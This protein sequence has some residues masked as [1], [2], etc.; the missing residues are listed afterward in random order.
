MFDFLKGGKATVKVTVDRPVQPYWLGET[1]QA[2]VTVNG[3]KDLKV[4]QARC[5]LVFHEEYEYRYRDT[6]RDSDGHEHTEEKRSWVTQEQVVQKELMSG[7]TT[8][9]GG[10]SQTFQYR[11]AIPPNAAPTASTGKIVKVKWLLKGILD[12][13]LLPDIA[14]N[15]EL[16]VFTTPPNQNVNPGLFGSSN[17]PGEAEL[18]FSLPRLEWVLGETLAGEFHIKPNKEFDAT[19]I[20]VELVRR[21]WV[22]RDLGNE[23]IERFAVK[24][25]QGTHFTPGQNM[26]LPFNF[27]LPQSAPATF[28]TPNSCV[29]WKV[30]GVLAR[31]LRGDTRAD[32]EIFVYNKHTA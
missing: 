30:S 12:R 15:V 5:E 25:A 7:E 21:E 31:R 16:L 9:K 2:T 19:E 1:V 29:E 23:S 8:I 24:L 13:K 11:F 32:Q 10:T 28:R 6:D 17:E 3:E 18:N 20:R 27:M 14:N 22:P 4:Q 26:V